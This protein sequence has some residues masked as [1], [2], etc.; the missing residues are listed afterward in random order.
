ML[1]SKAELN[2]GKLA[3]KDESRYTLQAI[4]VDSQCSVVTNGH[5]L[6]TVE[7]GQFK[8]A[9]YLATP[10]LEPAVLNGKPKLIHRETAIAA[11]KALPRKS[12]IPVLDTAALSTDGK[13]YVNDLENVQVFTKEV[14]GTFPNWQMVVPTGEPKPT[15]EIAFSSEYIELLAKFFREHGE[16]DRPSVV[17][18]TFYGN[19]H[20]MRIDGQTKEGQ[21]V[22][23]LL[24]PIR[25]EAADFVKR[26][27]EVKRQPKP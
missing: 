19:D 14:T 21:K 20:A 26:P 22:M 9:D 3:D 5:Y 18:F 8:D 23:A 27:H 15:T 12:T 16:K 17:R 11:S 7:H 6:V 2:L 13:L 4:A 1:L 25:I 24:M 10:G